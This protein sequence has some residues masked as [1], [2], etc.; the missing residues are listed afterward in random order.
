MIEHYE[1]KFLQFYGNAAVASLRIALVDFPR[2]A[3]VK[4]VAVS[5]LEVLADKLE[6][7]WGL[8]LR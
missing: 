7:D 6:R 5:G 2:R 8:K 4:S 3:T 1:A